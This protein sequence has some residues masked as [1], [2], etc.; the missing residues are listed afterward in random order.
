M[1]TQRG[2][3]KKV[4]NYAARQRTQQGTAASKDK[5]P[6][7]KENPELRTAIATVLADAGL[8]P[9]ACVESAL[10]CAGLGKAALS[11]WSR[12]SLPVGV[13]TTV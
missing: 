3:A 11:A 4:P 13:F 7:K 5:K 8:P 1:S 12:A 6:D 10:L 2:D 9:K